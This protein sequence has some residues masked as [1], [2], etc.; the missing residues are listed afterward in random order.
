MKV[1]EYFFRKRRK[2]R[3]IFDYIL[4]FSKLNLK[5]SEREQ[6]QLS[7]KYKVEDVKNKEM[8]LSVLSEKNCRMI[9]HSIRDKPKTVYDISEE[10]KVPIS[11]IYR[12]L[13][14]LQKSRLIATSGTISSEGKKIYLW[15]SRF[16]EVKT[17]FK[18]GNLDV[19]VTFNQINQNVS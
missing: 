8:I 12:K 9:L 10:I 6:K 7:K 19:N 3:M 16:E 14:N 5:T 17:Q 4:S 13:N 2:T 11:T 1:H 18:K 15:V